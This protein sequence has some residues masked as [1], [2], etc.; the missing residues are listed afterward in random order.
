MR[1][2]I[3]GGGVGGL[4]LGAALSGSEW[5]ADV[6]LFERRPKGAPAGMGFILMPNGLDALGRIAP[7]RDWHR[8]GTGVDRVI[9]RTASGEILSEHAADGARCVGRERFLDALRACAPVARIHDEVAV[10]GLVRPDPRSWRTRAVEL[11]DGS[12]IEGDLFLACDGARSATRAALMPEARLG[13]VVV[14]EIVSIAHCPALAA[15]LGGSFSKFHDEE[16]GFAVG[17]LAESR[18]RVVWFVQFDARRWTHVG[19]DPAGMAAFIETRIARWAD[20]VRT[21]FVHTDFGRSHLWPTRDLRPLPMLAQENLALVGDAAHACLPFTSQGANGALV[22]AALLGALLA[23]ARDAA[24]LPEALHEYSATRRPHHRRV[25]LE[26]RRLRE[27]FLAPISRRN[28]VIP[29]VR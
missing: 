25:F 7:G 6:R 15:A 13:E 21:A 8:E 9:L 4:A 29:L 10:H 12:E 2:I 26:G 18:E 11:D 22:D 5:G 23:D 1:S 20:E 3:I 28:P 27:A 19:G 24:D 14:K 16:G 17:M